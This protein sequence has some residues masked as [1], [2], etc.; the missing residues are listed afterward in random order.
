MSWPASLFSA[1]LTGLL[2]MFV[3]GLVAALAVDWYQISSREG[4][5]GYFV[6]AMSIL[7][8]GAGLVLGLI[9]AR[10]VSGSANPGFLRATGISLGMVAALGAVAAG[11]ARALADVPP[12]I[13]GE[14]LMLQVEVRWPESQTTAPV[15][16][17]RDEPSLGLHSIPRLSHTVRVSERGPLW[18]EDA[19]LVDGRWV[20]PGAVRVFTSRGTRMLTVELGGEKSQGFALPLRAFPR[21]QDT[22]WSEWLPNFRPGVTV[23][24]DLVRYRFRVQRVSQPIRSQTI[25]PFEV[26]TRTGYFYQESVDSANRFA[27]SASFSFRYNGQPLPIEGPGTDDGGTEERFEQVSEV[28]L[29]AGERTA[30][31]LRADS[32]NAF[33]VCFLLS[34]SGGAPRLQFVG[35]SGEGID[36]QLLTSDTARFRAAA[37]RTKL[38]GRIDR[39]SQ[40][41]PGL[42]RIGNT[43][44]DTRRLTL[45]HFHPDTGHYDVPSVPPLGLSPDERS[46]VTWVSANEVSPPPMLRVIDFVGDTSYTLPV[47]PTRMRW[48]KFESLDPAWLLHHFE[49]QRQGGVDRLVERPH[50]VPLP[51]RGEF[52]ASTGYQSY[53][54]EKGSAALRGVL[55]E[56]LAREFHA[57]Q[58]EADAADYEIPVTIGS[59]T[60]KVGFS[61][62]FG[63][64]MVSSDG[65]HPGDSTLVERIGTGF[66]AVLARGTYDS[67][68]TTGNP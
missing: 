64:V 65:P 63:Y 50:F 41:Q 42:Y 32:P 20:A 17:G 59:D 56:F 27:A 45:H 53:R 51:Y 35:V 43:V 9:V 1:L 58:G 57:T 31:L 13:D 26:L 22:T 34:D 5:S 68:F 24:P 55:L 6:I 10:T 19:H 61:T 29:I 54:W 40:S 62:D 52:S 47:D 12:E 46:F 18:L 67:L 30:F 33:G 3:S 21:L 2:A 39:V 25:G 66:D 60:L 14:T 38:R 44:V 28:A 36:G 15:A 37:G 48:A 23:P 8:L 11:V 4:G 49:W 16:V 7:G